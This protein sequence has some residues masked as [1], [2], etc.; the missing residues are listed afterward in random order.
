MGLET[1][2]GIALPGDPTANPMLLSGR[3][4]QGYGE[5]HGYRPK[6]AYWDYTSE[7]PLTDARGFQVTRAFA[8]PSML[9]DE[10]ADD[11][12]MANLVLRNGAR[13]YVDHAHPEYSAPEVLT[14]R[15]VVIWDRAGEAIMIAAAHLAEVRL[16]KNNTDGKGSSYGTHE[17]YLL[18]RA[19]P[20]DRIVA[21]LTPFFVARQV[22]CGAGRVGLGQHSEIDGY[23]LSSRADFFEAEVGLETT[24]RRP[25]INTRDEPHATPERYRRLHVIVGDANLAEVATYLKLGMT[26]LVLTVIEDEAGTGL[27]RDLAGLALARP[28]SALQAISHD[29][30]L[31]V[32]VDLADGRS[33]TGLD[34]LWACYETVRRHLDHA[35]AELDPETPDVLDR[36]ESVLARLGTDPMSCAAEL[37]WVAKLAVLQGYRD[38]DD[39]PW[40]NPRLRAVDIQY[41]DIDPARSLSRRLEARGR[42]ERL[43]TDEEVA[44]AVETAPEETRAWFRG[45]CVRRYGEHVAAA[46]W[47]SVVFDIPGTGSLQRVAALEPRRGTRDLVLDL[48]ERSPDAATLLREL[49]GG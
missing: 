7:S 38:R 15:D 2:Y 27:F 47:D 24:F 28:L 12:T 21:C 19:T 1:E 35:G 39:L 40:G 34:L 3:V 29:P 18:S 13:L 46:S 5:A 9:T 43:S 6:R 31:Q 36:W 22:I 20:F 45:E 25:I 44:A 10:W 32:V 26:S 37:D 42:L 11:P 49:T 48:L 8:P 33:M 17:N 41:S 16:Y 4:V 30:A 14:P 23:Q